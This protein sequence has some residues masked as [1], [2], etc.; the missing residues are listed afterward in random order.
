MTRMA[1]QWSMSNRRR[2]KIMGS[3]GFFDH[4]TEPTDEEWWKIEARMAAEEDAWPTYDELMAREDS[5]FFG[6]EVV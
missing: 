2:K 4:P 6:S 3:W 5:G 1:T